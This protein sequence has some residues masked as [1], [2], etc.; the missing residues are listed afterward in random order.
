MA[1]PKHKRPKSKQGKA[2]VGISLKS[3]KGFD[4]F[5]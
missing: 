5:N 2:K 1:V 3:G 4:I